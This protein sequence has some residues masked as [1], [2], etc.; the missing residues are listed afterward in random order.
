MLPGRAR[1]LCLID[2]PELED[3]AGVLAVR[4][5]PVSGA[6]TQEPLMSVDSPRAT[7]AR[8]ISSIDRKFCTG[9]LA[10]VFPGRSDR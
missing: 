3:A 1:G 4:D 5:G 8:L 10:F 6:V 2:R 9:I 7:G